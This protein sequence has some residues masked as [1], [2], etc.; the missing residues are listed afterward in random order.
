MIEVDNIIYSFFAGEKPNKIAEEAYEK[1]R[2]IMFRL[3]VEEG[4][5]PEV[6]SVLHDIRRGRN[7]RLSVQTK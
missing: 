6:G 2:E 1:Q 7:G 5:V 3:R 4:Y